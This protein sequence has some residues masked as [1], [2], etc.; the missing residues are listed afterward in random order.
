M[1]NLGTGQTVGL[2]EADGYYAS[3]IANYEGAAFSAN[4]EYSPFVP[5]T[6]VLIDGF[7][8]APGTGARGGVTFMNTTSEMRM[9][10]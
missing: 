6:N 7:N 3:D 2:F 10:R 5:L 4:S 8:G 9:P 1:T